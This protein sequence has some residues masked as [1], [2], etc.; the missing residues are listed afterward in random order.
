[1]CPSFGT[2]WTFFS[3]LCTREER[4]CSSRF[5]MAFE[6]R[7]VSV[8]TDAASF[9]F[10]RKIEGRVERKDLR[11]KGGEP[12]PSHPRREFLLLREK[13][14]R[15]RPCHGRGWEEALTCHSAWVG[16]WCDVGY[17]R[18][19]GD[20][21]EGCGIV[22][23]LFVPC[24]SV[25]DACRWDARTRKRSTDSDCAQPNQ[26]RSKSKAVNV[27]SLSFERLAHDCRCPRGRQSHT[28]HRRRLSP[29]LHPPQNPPTTP[30]RRI[31]CFVQGSFF[32]VSTVIL[33]LPFPI[34][35]EVVCL[36]FARESS[37]VV[38]SRPLHAMFA[39]YAMF[40]LRCENRARNKH[41]RVT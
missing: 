27:L 37:G 14:L 1:M 21:I 24:S 8:E 33:S 13:K 35:E 36:R 10:K 12:G 17:V 5:A 39:W 26:A 32:H 3:T 23:C 34:E 20:S 16:A 7:V 41:A 31:F 38:K 18:F 2:F 28:I 25:F 15:W 29:R 40:V 30:S 4:A 6:A 19:L 22:G 11:S 9:P